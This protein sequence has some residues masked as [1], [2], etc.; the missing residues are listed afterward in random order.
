MDVLAV[1]EATKWAKEFALENGPIVLEMDTYRYKV[2]LAALCI[3]LEMILAWYQGHSMSD[4]G[5]GYR[6]RKEVDAEKKTKDCIEQLRSRVVDLGLDTLKGTKV[7][8]Y[9]KTCEA[10]N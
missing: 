1:R 9:T 2:R 5:T 10:S 7:S 3:G 6:T 4:P 8:V